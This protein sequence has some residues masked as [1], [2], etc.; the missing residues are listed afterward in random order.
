[1]TIDEK[2]VIVLTEGRLRNRGLNIG[3]TCST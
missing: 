1:M 3:L 2:Y